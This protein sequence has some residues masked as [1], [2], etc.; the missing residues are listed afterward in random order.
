MKKHWSTRALALL[1]VI[2]LITAIAEQVAT[3]VD[4]TVSVYASGDAADGGDGQ[5]ITYT[6]SVDLGTNGNAPVTQE[7]PEEQPSPEAIR[8]YEEAAERLYGGGMIHIFNFRQL[9]LA[10]SGAE[11]KTGDDV[12]ETV[13]SGAQ[14]TDQ[15]GEPVTYAADAVYYLEGDISLPAQTQWNVPAGFSGEFT[16]ARK[17]EENA[18]KTEETD[19]GDNSGDGEDAGDGEEDGD[20]EDPDPG[21]EESPAKGALNQRLYDVESDTVYLQNGFQLMTLADSHRAEIPV[22]SNDWSTELFGTGQFI[23]PGDESLGYLTYSEGHRYVISSEFT[24]VKPGDESIAIRGGAKVLWPYANRDAGDRD[25]RDYAGQV[26]ANINGTDYI[27]I[28]TA[29]QLKAIDRGREKEVLGIA[30]SGSREDVAVYGPVYKLKVKR[31]RL[32]DPWEPDGDPELVYPGDADVTDDRLFDSYN[33]AAGTGNNYHAL[34]DT[35]GLSGTIYTTVDPATNKLN[36]SDPSNNTIRLEYATDANYIVFRNINLDGYD[37]APLMF[38]GTMYGVKPNGGGN[39]WNDEKTELNLSTDSKPVISNFSVNPIMKDGK[40]DVASQM[41]VGF[42]GTISAKYN[43]SDLSGTTSVVRNIHLRD[44]SVTNNCTDVDANETFISILLKGLPSLLGWVADGLLN[45]AVNLGNGEQS[46]NLSD[47]LQD[48]LDARKKDPTALATGAF[49]GRIVGKVEVSDCYVERVNVRSAVTVQ[50][51]SDMHKIVG[52]GGFVG[53]VQGTLTYSALDSVLGGVVDGLTWVLNL[54]PGIGLGD[55]VTILAQ[56]VL[57]L[58][59]IIPTGYVETKIDACT[60]DN[61][62]LSFGAGR[63]GVGGFAGSICGTELTWSAVRN[64]SVTLDAERGGGGF[65]GV[66]RDDIIQQLLSGLGI[67]VGTLYPQSEIRECQIRNSS[68][69]L[70]GNWSLGGFAGIQANSSVIN[71]VIDADSTVSITAHRDCAGGFTGSAQLGSGFCLPDYLP[72]NADLL[73]TV[74]T[75]LTNLLSNEGSQGL[76]E[77]GG[78]SN[79]GI[80]GCQIRGKVVVHT[81]GNIAGGLIGYG[82]G[83]YIDDSGAIAD[84]SRYRDGNIPVPEV[85]A[86]PV[87]VDQLV[88]VIASGAFADGNDGEGD[89]GEDENDHPAIDGK[90][91]LA[92]GGAGYLCSANTGTLLGS[93][94]GLQSHL[95]FRMEDV[96][97]DSEKNSSGERA[98]FR[99]IATGDFAGGAAGFAIGGDITRVNVNNVTLVKA[100]NHAG[101]FAGTTG[102]D[103]VVGGNGLSLTLLGINLLAINDLLGMTDG[104]HTTITDCRVNDRSSGLAVE[105]EATGKYEDDNGRTDYSAGGFF[106]DCTSATVTDCHVSRLRSVTSD[107]RCGRSGG[108]V[109]HCAAGDLSGISVG[110]ETV[111]GGSVGEQA[112]TVLDVGQLISLGLDIIPKL[113]RCDVTFLDGGYVKGNAA[114]GFAGE[115]RSGTL[116]IDSKEMQA[117]QNSPYAVYNIDHVEGGK[118]AGGFGGKVFSGALE[119]EGGSGLGL[120]NKNVKVDIAGI[121]SITNAYLPKLWYAG[122]YSEKGFTVLAAYIDDENSPSSKGYAGGYIGYGSGMEVSHCHVRSLKRR[123]P[124]KIPANL[125]D[126]DGTEYMDFTPGWDTVPYS[127]AGAEYAGGYIGCMNVGS[128]RALGDSISLMHESLTS[129]Q[130]LSGLDVVV[131]T[132]EHSNVYGLPGGFS[133]LASSHVNLG[134][135]NYDTS[136]FGY[137]GGYAGQIGGAHIQDGNSYKFSY[138]IGEIASGGYAGEMLPGDVADILD[139]EHTPQADENPEEPEEPATLSDI[140]STIIDGDTLKLVQAF[141]PTVYNSVTTCIPCGGVVRAQSLSDGR[142]VNTPQARGFAGGYVGHSSGGQIWGNSSEPWLGEENYSGDKRDCDAVRIRSVYGAEYAGG[143]VGLMEAGSTA[144]SGNLSLLGGIISADNLLEALDAVYPTIENANV[145]GPLEEMDLETW[146]KWLTYVAAKG[147]AAPEA[148]ELS[149]LIALGTFDN[150]DQLREA[151]SQFT[152]GYHAVAGRNEYDD[153]VFTTYGGCAGGYAGAMHSGVI[154][155]G[156]ASHAKLVSA[157]RAAGGYAGE[158]ITKGLVEFGEVNILGL[159]LALDNLLKVADVLTPVVFES[160]VTGYQ[161]GLVVRSDGLPTFEKIISGEG[162][163][164]VT[165]TISVDCGMAGGFVGGCYGGQLGTRADGRVDGEVQIPELGVWVRNCKTVTGR[166]CIGGFAGKTTAASVANADDSDASNGLIQGL[167]DTVIS[168][169]SQLVNALDATITVIGKA[170]VSGVPG[171]EWGIVVDGEYKDSNNETQ[172]AYCAGGFVGSSEATVFGAKNTPERTLIVSDLRGVSA[173]YYAGGFFGL[174]HVGSVAEVGDKDGNTNILHLLQTEDISVLDIFRTYI[175]H[176]TV[177]GVEDGIMIVAHDQSL[178]GSIGNLNLSGAAGGF[179]GAMMNGTVENSSVDTLNF[180]QAPNYAAGFVGLS[181]TS[182]GIGEDSL[183]IQPSEENEEGEEPDPEDPLKTTLDGLGLGDLNISAELL[184]VSGSVFRNCTVTGFTN[185]FVTRTTNIQTK[186]ANG[187]SGDVKG[188]CAAGFVG[189]ADMAHFDECAVDQFKFAWSTQ[190]AGGFA[191]RSALNYLVDIAIDSGLTGIL[192]KVVD[193]LVRGLYLDQAERADF[194]NASGDLLGLQVFSEGNVAAVNLFGLKISVALSKNDE[195]YNGARDAAIITIGSSTVKLPCDEN[196]I[197]EENAPDISVTLIEGNR[198]EFTHSTVKGVPDGYNIYAGRA[199]DEED[200]VDELGYAGGFI[201]YNDAGVIDYCSTELCDVIRGTPPAG[202]GQPSKVGPFT[203]FTNTRSRTIEILEGYHEA[204]GG[205]PEAYSNSFSVYRADNGGYTMIKKENAARIADKESEN[206]TVNGE[207]CNRY[208]VEHLGDITVHEDFKDATEDNASGSASRPLKAYV[209]PA[210][211]VLML[212]TA[213]DD[214]IVGDTPI[215]VDLKDPCDTPVDITVNKVWK[216]FIFL[217]SRPEEITLTI[218]QLNYGST[219]P[220]SLLTMEDPGKPVVATETITI[221]ASD[222]SAWT[223]AWQ[224]VLKDRKAADRIVSGEEETI[225][226]YQYHIS[227]VSVDNYD[228]SYEIDE[229]TCSLKITNRYTG[230]LLPGTGGSGTLLFIAAGLFLLVAGGM[231]I[232]FRLMPSDS[233]KRKLRTA[234]ADLDLSDFSDFL[235]YLK[236]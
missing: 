24:P 186:V 164:A 126:S 140:V 127:V 66:A 143:Y 208:I 130:L 134:D 86:K 74:K 61:C 99:V 181:G 211:A 80:L 232:A 92:G 20:G 151:F 48:L 56:N 118:F 3:S 11:L 150:E 28:G 197:D 17:M 229:S 10:G 72:V 113:E 231:L 183:G 58:D 152:Y 85:T 75:A 222:S 124:D 103:R 131:T 108:F 146:N 192:V 175:Y 153:G 180:A 214:N 55:L 82:E 209:S 145:F 69:I 36:L 203:G 34:N 15:N 202:E 78:V 57:H 179:G 94:L 217:D 133:V 219:V 193:V 47:T 9:Q 198:A 200:G 7:E 4:T 95:A 32:T 207:S 189:Y 188:S 30:V 160:G 87:L 81:S 190:N 13:G 129:T 116:N 235:K 112:V 76:L 91:S 213:L 38:T 114:G 73:S 194:F 111:S 100:N 49:A 52:C 70:T 65:V 117:V 33:S 233:R 93:T 141:I 224:K 221:V 18:G 205:E 154:R 29:A 53:H 68:V 64:M 77:L 90:Y 22:M 71:C 102:P 176:A 51:G 225:V 44:A 31:S 165:K 191:G 218:R 62:T 147:S 230:P 178:R 182:S 168:N 142:G 105:V 21:E 234:D 101:G 115:F 210:M 60:V 14:I 54:I 84:L 125:E 184:N 173:A 5:Y 166:N 67:T 169:P 167:L 88:E 171:T 107:M 43:D 119:R 216:D 174:A 83:V 23:Y 39:L 123:C 149:S 2:S 50:E 144:K 157:Y 37:W 236:K 204:D 1:L 220:P 35:T 196:G 121:A 162:D 98:G 40:L 97:I 63:Y 206:V 201:G 12:E 156:N 170:E 96:T 41:G 19:D 158:V 45:F 138:I 185:G 226:Y 132:I 110:N 227:E 104:I 79:S 159:D 136:G 25:G 177:S 172:Y 161:N 228:S 109:G 26:T 137:A 195:Q 6:G 120:L 128:A 42:F 187:H 16:S 27:L 155:Y 148:N 215:T 89:S 106:G 8:A 212:D 122:V 135:K 46:I 163:D 59:Q 199:T 223:T 139:V